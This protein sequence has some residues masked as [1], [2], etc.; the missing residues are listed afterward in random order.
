MHPFGTAL[1][2]SDLDAA[3]ALLADDVVFYSPVVYAPYRGRDAVVVILAAVMRVFE[4]F[5]YTQ[6]IAAPNGADHCL[7]FAARIGATEVAGCDLLHCRPD[8]LVDRLI[9]M[10]RPIR[11]AYT[12]AEAMRAGLS[13]GPASPAQ[14]LGAGP[15]AEWTEDQSWQ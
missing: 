8:G 9:V 7:V 1:A 11:A 2:A 10:V 12:L 3:A 6:A 13:T 5:G 4:A 14:P 15:S